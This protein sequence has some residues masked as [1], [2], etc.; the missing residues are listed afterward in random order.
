MQLTEQRQQAETALVRLQ[1]RLVADSNQLLAAKLPRPEAEEGEPAGA[2][3]EGQQQQQAN[4]GAAAAAPGGA[5]VGQAGPAARNPFLAAPWGEP[6]SE[7]QQQQ[8]QQPAALPAGSPAA[9]TAGAE[10]PAAGSS[11]PTGDRA[12]LGAAQRLLVCPTASCLPKLV[13]CQPACLQHAP[14][15]GHLTSL[16]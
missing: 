15:I 9:G 14:C 16:S 3:S 4:G 11:G 7:E 5:G 8:P 2:P 13:T 6:E 1:A 12:A 10:Q